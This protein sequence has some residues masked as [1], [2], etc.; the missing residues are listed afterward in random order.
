MMKKRIYIIIILLLSGVTASFSAMSNSL[1]SIKITLE[2]ASNRLVQ[3]KAYVHLDN[4][5][6]FIGETIWYKAYVMRADNLKFTDMSRILYVE[7]LS[8]DGVVVERQQ[9]IVSPNGYGYGDFAL[10]DSL[11]SGFYEIRAYTRWML[12][13]NVTEHPYARKDRE[14]FFN[15][16]MAKDYF[17]QYDALYSRVIPVYSKPDTA[18][19]VRPKRRDER[20]KQRLEQLPADNL[21]VKFYPEGG[22]LIS[23]MPAR[24][25]FEVTNRQGMDVN[26]AGTVSAEKEKKIASIKTSYMG[27]GVFT[28]NVPDDRMKAS[29]N[30]KGK[31]YSFNLPK[32]E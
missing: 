20:P 29:F 26:I 10:K 23:G 32:P 4:T 6:Y 22:H 9:L 21:Q 17:R 12:N 3:E 18:Y 8:P 24:I 19:D 13:F 1:D 28:V 15:F 2:Q 27:R 31:E 7:L 11:Y 30:Y 14:A 16:Q 5:C 25:A